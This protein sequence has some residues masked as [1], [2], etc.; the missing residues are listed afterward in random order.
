MVLLTMAKCTRCGSGGAK[1][2]CPA[3]DA[4]LCASCCARNQRRPIPCP[5]DCQFLR[6][7]P[8]PGGDKASYQSAMH[9]LIEFATRD[10]Q[11]V[12]A[13]LLLLA[14]P[15]KAI[16]DWEEP[17]LF[18]Y[19]AYGHADARGD[20]AIDRMLRG[21]RRELSDAEFAALESLQASAWPSL[22]E[23]QAVQVDVGLQL[24]DLITG[25]A[26]FVREQ[27]ATHQAKKFDLLLGWV[28][29]FGDHFELTGDAINVPRDDRA[30]VLGGLNKEL[31]ALRKRQPG[32]PD[33]V[34]QR[35]AII[36][37]QIA[38]RK[39]DAEWRPPKM[40][41]MDG[42]QIVLCEALFDLTDPA[43]ARARLVAH[44]DFDEDDQGIAWVDRKGRQGL[45][46]GPLLLG[47][48]VIERTRLKLETR[49]RERLERGKRLLAKLLKGVARHRVDAIK[50]F[51]VALS[52]FDDRPPRVPDDAIPDEDEARIIGPLMQKHIESWIDQ[53]IPLLKGKTPRQACKTRAGRAKVLALLKDH[54]NALQRQPGGER[55]DFSRVYRELGLID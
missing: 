16:G 42:E 22:F 5:P 4:D 44:A 36:G 32:T 27:A 7:E 21:H 53:P 20:R 13:A 55:V 40:T 34:L 15:T 50:D 41:T 46:D 29:R 37:G 51:D 48:I 39:A 33:R 2:P 43:A 11:R 14:G 12:S 38:M 9:K 49:S 23:I 1:R 47:S 25:N 28:T 54:E 3:L 52:E 45:G 24:V 30:V 17:L 18:A 10:D 6:P 26:V 19:L 8:Q 35:E 31:R